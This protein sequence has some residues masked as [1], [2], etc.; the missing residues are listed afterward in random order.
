M[1]TEDVRPI[2]I[3]E[4]ILK[5][6]DQTLLPGTVEWKELKTKEDVW[7]AIQKLH[8]RGAPA[9]GVAAAY[10]VWIGL[11]DCKAESLAS[12]QAE[13]RS[14]AEYLNSSRPTA[15][16]L[17]WA[18]N[19]MK[20]VIDNAAG[21]WG[22]GGEKE[23]GWKGSLMVSSAKNAL[24]AEAE[25]IHREDED[26]CRQMG[27]KGLTLLAP[28]M[29]ILTY[30]NAGALA[31]ARYGTAL[32]PLYLGQEQGYNFKVFACE[33]RPLLQGARLTTWELQQAGIDV[34]LICDNMA[35]AVIQKGWIDAIL[36]G[37]DRMSANG[38]MANKIGTS[39]LAI[40]AKEYQIPFYVFAP[41]SSIDLSIETGKEIP[42]EEREGEE[43]TEMWYKKRMAPGGVKVFNPAFDV[44]LEK[45]ITAVITE[46]GIAYPP[47]MGSLE[48]LLKG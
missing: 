36:V 10:G 27:E 29:G 8:V 46:K 5:V 35:A 14:V 41:S 44:T 26:N 25:A 47:Y 42:I 11:K 12:L 9:I 1:K 37:C 17:F 3:E 2:K 31:T 6:I 32:S 45:Y 19:R 40:L 33:T 30:C 20:D 18:L 16:N 13:F 48:T 24:L 34:T 39:T 7:N 28:G 22:P 15:V 38:D 43:I 4:G 21:L 23:D